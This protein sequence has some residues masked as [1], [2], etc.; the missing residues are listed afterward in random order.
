MRKNACDLSINERLKI[1]RRHIL[2][3]NQTDFG[4]PVG[5][6]QG[7]IAGYEAQRVPSAAI[8]HAICLEY[9]I[10]EQWLNTGVGEPLLKEN[11]NIVEGPVLECMEAL[12]SIYGLDAADIDILTEYMKLDKGSRKII[13]DFLGNI[14]TITGDKTK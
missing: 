8:I 6:A 11:K 10:N 3:M 7:T 12:S 1:V 5:L 2:K 14:G 9:N 4:K 13:R